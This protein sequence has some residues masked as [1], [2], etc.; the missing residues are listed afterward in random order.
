MQLQR[1]TLYI[2]QSELYCFIDIILYD[3]LFYCNLYCISFSLILLT[4]I[5][6]GIDPVTGVYGHG[7]YNISTS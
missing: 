3:V 7:Y 4:E 6:H 5:S 2:I 1:Y